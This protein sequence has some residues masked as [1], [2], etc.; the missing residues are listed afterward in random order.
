VSALSRGTAAFADAAARLARWYQDPGLKRPP[1]AGA[2]LLGAYGLRNDVIV[3]LLN[4]APE[5]LNMTPAEFKRG[6]P[7]P[8]CPNRQCGRPMLLRVSERTG[9]TPSRLVW[10]CFASWHPRTQLEVGAVK[11]PKADLSLQRMIALTADGAT[12]DWQPS[13]VDGHPEPLVVMPTR[14][15]RRRR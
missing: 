2:S 9:R 11:M 5:I 7:A 1:D 10:R 15:G 6:L 4:T 3:W 8:R 14:K 12:L 13:L